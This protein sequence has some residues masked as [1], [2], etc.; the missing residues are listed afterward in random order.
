MNGPIGLHGGG[1]YVAGDEPYLDA[2][3]RAAVAASMLR[4]V[5]GLD[6]SGA[7]D[8]LDPVDADVSGHA[9]GTA[10]TDAPI[11][12][13]IVPTA[14]ARGQPDRVAATGRDAFE[15]RARAGGLR[16][17]VEVAR[18]V[19]AASADD[20]RAA[21]RLAEADLIHLPGGDPDI[22]PAVL[23]GSRAM[24]AIESARRR[25]AVIAGA[26]AG[27]MAL[28]EWTW[29]PDGGIRG[30]NFATGLVVVPHYDDVRRMR[31]QQ[32]LDELAPGGIGYLGLDERTGVISIADGA[33]GSDWLVAGPGA[34]Y[35]FARGA[36]EPI[37]GRHGEVVRLSS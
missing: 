9:M 13:A 11:R 26:S 8:D 3:L 16:V 37:V 14:A 7:P 15:R 25:G 5:A 1:E 21:D 24:A 33:A 31:W 23:R 17:T 36:A 4:A 12:I 35:W 20:P 30:L 27:A 19:D 10:P 29:T 28:A 2:L 22:I 18:I 6:F 34:A 32:S